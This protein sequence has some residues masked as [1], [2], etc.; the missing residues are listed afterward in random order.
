MN[1]GL[2]MRKFFVI[3]T[4]IAIIAIS[5]IIMLSGP[6]LKK[7]WG[8]WDNVPKHIDI[9][10][11]AILSDDW[12]LAEQNE[13]KLEADWKAVIKRIQFSGERDEINA[14]S[15]SIARLKASII[16]RDKVSA[17]MELSET[18]EHWE[19]LCK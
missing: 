5:M 1:G 14:L 16:V 2:M 6:F 7:P 19:D 11:K 9:T 17:L 13:G 12:I 15:V 3:F 10:T 4:P 18:G 8:E